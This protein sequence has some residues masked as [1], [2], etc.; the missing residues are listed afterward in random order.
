AVLQ[1]EG[2][3][4]IRG[5]VQGPPSATN[6]DLLALAGHRI[7]SAREFAKDRASG[8]RYRGVHLDIF[9]QGTLPT[10]AI[11]SRRAYSAGI[12]GSL[13][14]LLVSLPVAQSL[15]EP[16]RWIFVA[17]WYSGLT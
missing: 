2:S 5:R 16:R 6:H 3:R 14:A 17:A 10:T 1:E 9:L 8:R 7:F 13:P 12:I 4:A 15:P 11:R